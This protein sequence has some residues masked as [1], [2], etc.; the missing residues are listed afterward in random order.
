MSRSSINLRCSF[1]IVV[2]FPPTAHGRRA[3]C[4]AGS[5]PNPESHCWAPSRDGS[6]V[7]SQSINLIHK[8]AAVGVGI[9]PGAAR[10]LNAL[11]GSEQQ[12][13]AIMA[14][15]TRCR[16]NKARLALAA[17]L[18][19]PSRFGSRMRITLPVASSSGSRQAHNDAVACI[20][21]TGM[22]ASATQQKLVSFGA[23]VEQRVPLSTRLQPID[24][25]VPFR[26]GS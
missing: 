9:M 13:S 5:V 26:P 2:G 19:M 3:R 10:K 25:P 22:L 7:L 12:R 14:I 8:T 18:L 24:G 16:R 1:P 23:A 17:A 21:V 15:C 4:D 6:C 11:K 20:A